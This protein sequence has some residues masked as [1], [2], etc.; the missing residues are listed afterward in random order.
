MQSIISFDDDDGYSDVILHINL[1]LN[2][3]DLL[4][5]CKAKVSSRTVDDLLLLLFFSFFFSNPQTNRHQHALG[6]KKTFEVL[7]R[8][9]S[10][11]A[12]QVVHSS[13]IFL[14]LP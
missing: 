3:V 4:F 11:A 8:V 12:M 9:A 5:Y 6:R 13:W 14:Q 2:A 1:A 7:L 10:Q